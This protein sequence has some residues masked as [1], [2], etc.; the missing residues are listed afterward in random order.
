MTSNYKNDCSNFIL[1]GHIYID[2]KNQSRKENIRI[3]K[4]SIW[5][6]VEKHL[7]AIGHYIG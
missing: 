1:Q 6:L 7:F 4:I 2:L 5:D 3:G